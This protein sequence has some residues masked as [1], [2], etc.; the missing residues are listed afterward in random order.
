[1]GSIPLPGHGYAT[2]DQI[3]I[4]GATGMTGINGVFT[5]TVTGPNDYMLN[6][7]T[8]TSGY[9]AN[10]ANS[11]KNVATA[12]S[13]SNRQESI[14]TRPGSETR[15]AGHTPLE[16]LRKRFV[17]TWYYASPRASISRDGRYVAYASNYGIP[18]LAS[19]WVIDA[20]AS[21]TTTR[22][23]LKGVDAADTKAVINYDV[24]AGETAALITISASPELTASD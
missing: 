9:T 6:G 19:I 7:N 5:I 17:A 8:C 24:P 15:P 14:M 10:S 3:L 23:A 22:V 21:I 2:G 16:D 20:G 12:G 18:E 11:V 4:G 13:K 1:V